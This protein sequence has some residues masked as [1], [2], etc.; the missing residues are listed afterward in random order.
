MTRLRALVVLASAD[1]TYYPGIEFDQEDEPTA[2]AWV[3]AGAATLVTGD[4]TTD[5]PTAGSVTE[6]EPEDLEALGI[7]ALRARARELGLSSSGKTVELVARIRE[8]LA[9]ATEE[10]EPDGGSDT[11]PEDP[12]QAADG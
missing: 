8:T 2:E 4:D 7:N 10:E 9:T 11:E 5:A 12:D 6:S 1:G 3:A